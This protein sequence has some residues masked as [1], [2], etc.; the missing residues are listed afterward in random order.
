MVSKKIL[1]SGLFAINTSLTLTMQNPNKPHKT[2]T[3][4]ALSQ[5][6]ALCFFGGITN[7]LGTDLYNS[8]GHKET[9]NYKR[10]ISILTQ[11]SGRGS[12]GV[13]LLSAAYILISQYK[14]SHVKP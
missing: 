14:I 7:K 10:A 6:A 13:G 11:A 2:F 4:L 5:S 12:I 8:I 9:G 3:T 1:L